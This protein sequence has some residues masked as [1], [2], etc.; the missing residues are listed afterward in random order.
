VPPEGSMLAHAVV[1]V[2]YF[3]GSLSHARERVFPDGAAELIVMLDEPHR[4]GDAVTEP[5]FPSICINGLRTRPSV[6][7]APNGRC[8]VLGIR[9]TPLGACSI[10]ADTIHDLRDVTIDLASALGRDA[11][12][13]AERCFSAT[14]THLTGRG[15][16]AA[17]VEAA[18]EWTTQR[19]Q[20]SASVES[21]LRHVAYEIERTKGTV[22]LER[23]TAAFAV[24]RSVVARRFRQHA[25]ITPKRFARIVRFNEALRLL[26]RYGNA[27][28]TAAGLAYF[29]QAHMYRDFEEFAGMAP[30][31]FL[32]ANRY[33]GSSSLAE[34]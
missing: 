11:V 16:A 29:D 25:G 13:L 8:R 19:L 2:W 10:I 12:H 28:R 27:G 14:S 31:A 4:D 21:V 17:V 23:I 9:L 6:V 24:P 3:D 15:S 34:A 32:A 33:P 7:V 1:R 5:N 22:P 30:G 20:R 18:I 26:G